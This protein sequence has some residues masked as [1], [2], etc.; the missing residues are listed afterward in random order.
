MTGPFTGRMAFAVVGG[1][2]AV[3]IAVNLTLA[4]LASRSHPGMVVQ[5]SYVAS[6]KFN[7][8]LAD[9]RAQKA[10]GWEV[11]ASTDAATFS[12]TAANALGAPLSGLT[13]VATLEHPLGAQ[14]AR[15]IPL[16]EVAPGRYAAPHGL[17]PGR[18][19]AEVRL[20]RGSERFYLPA[21]LLVPGSPG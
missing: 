16:A 9:G 18:W 10:L 5:N 3:V 8:W 17:A 4:T 11:A 19:R 15:D 14:A 21:D 13:A 12:L 20:S 7:S 2:F 1:G 6:Q